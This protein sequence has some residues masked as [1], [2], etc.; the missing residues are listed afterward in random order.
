MNNIRNVG[1]LTVTC[2]YSS[3]WTLLVLLNFLK[4][5]FICAGLYGLSRVVTWCVFSSSVILF[6]PLI[7][8]VELAQIEEMQRNQQKQVTTH[9]QKVMSY[10]FIN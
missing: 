7:L 4:G 1:K 3:V 6:A 2:N 10:I 9:T 5:D 8:E